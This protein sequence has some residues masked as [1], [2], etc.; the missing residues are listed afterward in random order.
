MICERCM[1]KRVNIIEARD[2]VVKVK[3][4]PKEIK[5]LLFCVTVKHRLFFF[6]VM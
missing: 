6:N 5:R 4:K 1:Y 2:S 3:T